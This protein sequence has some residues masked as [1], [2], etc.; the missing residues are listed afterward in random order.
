MGI[1]KP[2]RRN[3]DEA[4][5][6]MGELSLVGEAGANGDLGQGEALLLLQVLLGSLN[7][8]HDHILVWRQPGGRLELPSLDSHCSFCP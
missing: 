4:L 5:E 1:R 3:A 2:S 6:V 7:P 8:A